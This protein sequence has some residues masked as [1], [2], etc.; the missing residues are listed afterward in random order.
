MRGTHGKASGHALRT[1]VRSHPLIWFF[2]LTLV[3]RAAL[4]VLD[5]SLDFVDDVAFAGLAAVLVTLVNDQ[6]E[7]L[8][9]HDRS[10]SSSSSAR[11]SSMA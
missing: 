4:G 1:S 5:I 2:A 8:G 7:R 3:P 11:P 9:G 6:K 10:G